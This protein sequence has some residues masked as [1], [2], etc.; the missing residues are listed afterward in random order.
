MV[1]NHFANGDKMKNNHLIRTFTLYSLIA[2]ALMGIVL[3]F[4]I[5]NHIKADKLANIEEAA[6]VTVKVVVNN[7]LQRSDF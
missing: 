4:V 2:F 6:Q 7:N 3:S 1:W 5:Y